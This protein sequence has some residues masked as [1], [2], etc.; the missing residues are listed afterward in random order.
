V[1]TCAAERVC[2]MNPASK[3][4]R[5]LCSMKGASLLILLPALLVAAT[6]HFQGAV[7]EVAA[8]RLA[9]ESSDGSVLTLRTNAQSR[10]LEKGKA[11]KLEQRREGNRLEIDALKDVKGVFVIVEARLVKRT[12]VDEEAGPPRLT[13]RS[14]EATPSMATRSEA[15]PRELKLPDRPEFSEP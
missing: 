3:L 14:G 8:D 11:I 1:E 2:K 10:F 6:L 12:Q 13:R 4:P 15:I 9:L 5:L 7:L